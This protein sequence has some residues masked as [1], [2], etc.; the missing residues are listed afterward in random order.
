MEM[1][2]TIIDYG[3]GIYAIDQQMVR[4]FVIVGKDKTVLL[5]TGAIKVDILSFIKEITELPVQVILTHGDRDHITNLSDFKSAWINEPDIAV[6][7]SHEE[8]DQVELFSLQENEVIDLGGKRLKV[9]FTPGHTWGSICLLDEENKI[10]FSGDTV[11]YGPIFMFGMVR[12]LDQYQDSLMKLKAMKEAGVFTTVYCCHNSCPVPA[13]LVDDLIGCVEGIKD[14]SIERKPAQM[15]VKMD[16]Q[17]QVC[18]YGNCAIL[19]QGEN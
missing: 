15:P 1:N 11:S 14:G 7:R 9:L 2:T 3:N 6:V 17:P 16:V 5:D 8:Y 4:A 18:K 10:L 13:D 19:I 12:D